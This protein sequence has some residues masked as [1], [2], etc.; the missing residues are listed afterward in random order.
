MTINIALL[1]GINVGGHNK[2]KMVEL[3]QMFEML[4]FSGVQ[5]YIQSGNVLF[6][7]HESEQSLIK[8]IEGEI[9]K[10]FGFSINVVIRTASELER[11]S[12]N[13]PF[14]EEAVAEAKA[15][16]DGESLY[17]SLLQDKPS[18]DGIDRIGA[19]K[20]DNDKFM[21]EGRE[22][23]LL[24]RLGVRNAKLANNLQR[25]DV[26][27]TMRNWK[28]INRLTQLAKEMED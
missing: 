22:V 3:R 8:R 12:N 20:S 23:Y 6:E 2:I 21:I 10:V 25:L 14:T 13:C 19:Y 11:I 18:Q 27:S 5:T 1:R 15:T 26:P 9:E 4:G 28:T 16:S 17:I 7:S 24:F